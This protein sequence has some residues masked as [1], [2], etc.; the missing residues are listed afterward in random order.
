VNAYERFLAE[1]NDKRVREELAQLA[2]KDA[3]SNP[4][5]LRLR[6]LSHEFQ[7]ILTDVFF[8]RDSVL[9]ELNRRYGVF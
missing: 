1:L 3:Y 4:V 2:P 5:F 9:R 7:E 6:D 8:E